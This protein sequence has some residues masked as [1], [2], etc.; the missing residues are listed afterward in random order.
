MFD[1]ACKETDISAEKITEALLTEQKRSCWMLKWRRKCR[2]DGRLVASA[3]NYRE[4]VR[5][6][7]HIPFF[8]EVYFFRWC[9]GRLTPL[10]HL[11]GLGRSAHNH[12]SAGC[13]R[14]FGGHFSGEQAALFCQRLPQR[15]GVQHLRVP[16]GAAI[17]PPPA[18][19][20]SLSPVTAL[21][22]CWDLRHRVVAM[23]QQQGALFFGLT[24]FTPRTSVDKCAP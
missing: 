14:P 19:C 12:R 13:L 20:E 9:G 4:H 5:S 7:F 11:Q 24:S 1:S 18:A 23:R 8:E 17:L 16:Q 10:L 2:W 3:G 22:H 21:N 6:T 15:P